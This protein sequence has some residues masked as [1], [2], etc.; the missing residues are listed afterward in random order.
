MNMAQST[1][2]LDT[3][4]CEYLHPCLYAENFC[5]THGAAQWFGKGVSAPSLALS[6]L[7]CNSA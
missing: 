2:R 5:G 4:T 3:S 6:P 7:L 1:A